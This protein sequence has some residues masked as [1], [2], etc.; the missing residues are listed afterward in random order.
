MSRE[1]WLE[2]LYG[3]LHGV[4]N[5]LLQVQNYRKDPE[6]W[7]S[8]YGSEVDFLLEV[9]YDGNVHKLVTTIPKYT[10]KLSRLKW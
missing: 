9:P 4:L 5:M 1:D 8:S 6:K 3:H 7:K 2:M 10:S